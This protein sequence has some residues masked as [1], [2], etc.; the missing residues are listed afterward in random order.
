MSNEQKKHVQRAN[1]LSHCLWCLLLAAIAL[2]TAGLPTAAAD[3]EVADLWPDQPPGE[4]AVLKPEGDLTSDDDKLI[5]GKSVIRLGNVSVPQIAIYP[6]D[7]S[8]A[9]G[10]AVIICP[11]G[12]HHIL[13]YDLE[14]TEVAE[15][16]NA[17]GVTAVVLKYRVPARTPEQ[18]WLA[19]VQDAQ[20]AV[21]LVRHQAARWR[22]DPNRIGICGFS[23]GG[24][25]AALTSIFDN[26][27]QYE[28]VDAAD[29]VSSRPDFA[30]LIYPGGLVTKDESKLQ[31]HVQISPNAPATFL[32]HAFDDHASVQN[33][34]LYAS[35]LKR[36]GVSTELHIYPTGGHGY[37]LRATNEPI[38][39]WPELAESWMRRMGLLSPQRA[40]NGD[41]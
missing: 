17:I 35:G 30:M 34:L 27:R 32:I 8:I 7:E 12:G 10:T 37:G 31:E 14:G 9:N 29:S 13:A 39:R 16:L 4:A 2:C 40:S 25:T 18:R 22:I 15:W 21:S 26:N 19:A 5:A 20:R 3:P 36:A 24:E 6:A 11:G 28:T 33:S 38:T 23:A 1:K 41:R